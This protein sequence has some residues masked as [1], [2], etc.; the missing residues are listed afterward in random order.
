MQ[1][2]SILFFMSVKLLCI[3]NK[4]FI[5]DA[6]HTVNQHLFA[7]TLFHVLLPMNWFET[8]NMLATKPYPDCFV[9]TTILQRVIFP[10]CQKYE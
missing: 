7:T 6:E 5:K 1:E 4:E 9:I 2:A 3:I 10:C 8:T